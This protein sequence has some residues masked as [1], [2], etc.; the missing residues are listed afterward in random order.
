MNTF[1]ECAFVKTLIAE[2]IK[3]VRIHDTLYDIDC[4]TF[5]LG[6][7]K[8][9]QSQYNTLFLEIKKYVYLCRRKKLFFTKYRWISYEL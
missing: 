6:Y 3:I 1:W 5:V 9:S 7:T 2:I 4:Q 8:K